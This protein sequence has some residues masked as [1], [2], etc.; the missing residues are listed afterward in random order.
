MS[1]TTD[2]HEYYLSQI[3][4]LKQLQKVDDQIYEVKK[5]L[6][7]APSEF[8]ELQDNFTKVEMQRNH[9]NDKISH[10]RDQESRI[11]REM[12][13]EKARLK[14]SKNKLMATGS[15][16]EFHAVSREIDNMSKEMF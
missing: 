15:E 11:N 7:F 14:K 8:K 2:N 3:H 10:L 6:E 1:Q 16:K 5:V 13:E 9:I 4:Q 12:E